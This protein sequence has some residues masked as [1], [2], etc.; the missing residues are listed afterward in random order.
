[1]ILPTA[2]GDAEA[3]RTERRLGMEWVVREGKGCIQK[4]TQPGMRAGMF[5]KRKY[6][7]RKFE[8]LQKNAV[9]PRRYQQETGE[10]KH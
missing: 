5:Y 8:Q 2:L 10:E 1:M 4:N 6:E 3:V 9:E 7:V